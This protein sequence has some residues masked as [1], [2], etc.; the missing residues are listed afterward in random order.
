MADSNYSMSEGQLPA[1]GFHTP[2]DRP[3]SHD[4]EQQEMLAE[5]DESV[6]AFAEGR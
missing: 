4:A 1:E 2:G 5:L 3:G 6:K